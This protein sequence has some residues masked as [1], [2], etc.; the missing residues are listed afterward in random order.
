[1]V[2]GQ[3]GQLDHPMGLRN[4]IPPPMNLELV[5]TTQLLIILPPQKIPQY[6]DRAG[7]PHDLKLP[8]IVLLH[9]APP[10]IFQSPLYLMK[11]AQT[12]SG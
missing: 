4:K 9:W 7:A 10:V 8:L 1:M 12:Y 2:V 3:Q 6:L 5:R 11:D